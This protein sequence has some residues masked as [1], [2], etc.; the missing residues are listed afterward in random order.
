MHTIHGFEE[1]IPFIHKKTLVVCDIDYT[2]VHYGKP[3][4]H[5]LNEARSQTRSPQDEEPIA[6]EFY[7][8]HLQTHPPIPTD[9]SGFIQLLME[10]TRQGKLIFVTA[11]PP[12]YEA[13]TRK[14]FKTLNLD[15]DF[16]EVHYLG[17]GCKG[18]FCKQYVPKYDQIC[19][20]DD[21]K[22]N[23]RAFQALIPGSKTFLFRL[24]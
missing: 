21:Y 13:F 17:L 4:L 5:F 2:L 23:I 1:V 7:K 11:R 20:V 16:F 22:K 12:E 6:Y 9:P 10:V 24:D 15:Y 18:E 19:L 3:F 14:E 8:R